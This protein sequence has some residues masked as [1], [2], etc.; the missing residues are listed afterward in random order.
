MPGNAK[1]LI[2]KAL[3][4]VGNSLT[5]IG[6]AGLILVSSGLIPADFFT[7]GMSSGI[8]VIGSVAVGGCLLSAIGYGA[9]EYF[10]N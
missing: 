10:D 2:Y 5:V 6:C 8:R 4:L 9:V 7:I 1:K 3:I